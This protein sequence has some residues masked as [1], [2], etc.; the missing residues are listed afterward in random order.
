MSRRSCVGVRVRWRAR[1]CRVSCVV[2]RVVSCAYH[3][4]AAVAHGEHGVI[5]VIA[6]RAARS[7][8]EHAARVELQSLLGVNAHADLCSTTHTTRHT[9]RVRAKARQGAVL[10]RSYW[11]DGG[12]G[13]SE[14][15]F[16]AG[17][18]GRVR[19][20]DGAHR[21]QGP[22]VG[23]RAQLGRAAVRDPHR[24]QRISGLR[25]DALVVDHVPAHTPPQWHDTTRHD[26]THAHDMDERVVMAADDD[27]DDE[28]CTGRPGRAARR[29][30]PCRPAPTSSR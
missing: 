17:R 22:V 15:G 12:K 13:V 30:S 8:R 28:V 18:E 29:R 20:D 3:G 1:V 16:A 7:R 26:T 27:D 14:G 10:A 24:R 21:P 6:S 4:H 2:C 23:A 11:S 5:E 9:T 25:V 19:R